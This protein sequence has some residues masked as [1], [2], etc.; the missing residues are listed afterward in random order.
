MAQGVAA[1][2]FPQCIAESTLIKDALA[3]MQP[4]WKHQSAS[5][6]TRRTTSG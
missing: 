4:A 3:S 5:P 6:T 1:L 2:L